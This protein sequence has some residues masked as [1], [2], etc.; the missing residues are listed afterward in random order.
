M[1]QKVSG[2]HNAVAVG[3]LRDTD[4]VLRRLEIREEELCVFLDGL[5]PEDRFPCLVKKIDDVL[6][7]D[8]P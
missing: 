6:V 4:G 5:G 3:I 2:I 7:S 8:I 1:L